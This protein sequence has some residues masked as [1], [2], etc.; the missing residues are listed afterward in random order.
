[1]K[2]RVTDAAIYDE[3]NAPVDKIF[4]RTDSAA[5]LNLITCDGAWNQKTRD[6][7]KRLVVYA[8]RVLD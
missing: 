3:T 2:F 7:S 8:E 1:I 6:Y 5:H 4:D